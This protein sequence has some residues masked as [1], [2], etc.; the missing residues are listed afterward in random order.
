MPH[1]CEQLIAS[2]LY[3]TR[4]HT[5][6]HNT[7]PHAFCTT[8][9]HTPLHNTLSHGMETMSVTSSHVQK[10][11]VTEM[12]MCRWACGHTLRDHVRNENIKE[13]LTVESIAKR[14]R[15]ARL[16]WFGQVKRRYQDY[17]GRKTLEMVPP[18]RRK[19]GRPKQLWMDCV[20]R[21]SRLYTIRCHTHLS[22]TLP[23]ACKQHAASLIYTTRCDTPLH[24]DK[25]GS[26]HKVY[27]EWM[28]PISRRTYLITCAD[29]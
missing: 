13:R 21:D 22:N 1:A 24:N 6:L 3:T 2:R 25:R 17:V 7:L 15:K 14:C 28:W 26:L 23:Y 4:C 5:P 18:G 20:N 16:M 9:C 8:C 10:L 11:E 19:R 27:I 12:K 29:I